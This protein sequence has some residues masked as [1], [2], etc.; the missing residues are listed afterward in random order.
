VKKQV[1]SLL[2]ALSVVGVP[3]GGAFAD[4][5]VQLRP[6]D[7]SDT[8]SSSSSSYS[9]Y[10][11]SSY[12]SGMTSTYPTYSSSTTTTTDNA[13]LRPLY[14]RV[15]TIPAGTTMIVRLNQPVSSYANRAGE[16]ITGTLESDIFVNDTVVIPAGSEVLGQVSRSQ[17]ATRLGK[18][19]E[20]DIQFHSI[21]M[22]NQNAVPITGHIVTSDKTGVLKGD[23]Y[24]Q[25]IAKGVGIAA[26][27]TA[28]GAVLGT[29][30]GSLLG[31]AGTGAVFGTAVG[32]IAGISYA[33]LH[34]GKEVV[35]PSGTR[36]SVTLDQQVS[37]NP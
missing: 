27:S 7:S 12:G 17:S 21:K 22:P 6:L 23:T 9:G 24:A 11:T 1:F 19:G 2:L 35:V 13:G 20:L 30:S 33:L 4:G 32:G 31:S 3:A 28:V 16:S 29:A 10:G 8:Y 37:V 18:D 25:E 14:G 26:G 15:S 36:M 5:I 34:K